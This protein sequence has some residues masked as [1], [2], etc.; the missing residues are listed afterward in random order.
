[1]RFIHV[2]IRF[3]LEISTSRLKRLRSLSDRCNEIS[4][5]FDV[6]TFLHPCSYT[7]YSKEKVY[8]TILLY[9]KRVNWRSE[10]S[11]QPESIEYDRWTSFT[12]RERR[13]TRRNFRKKITEKTT[14][15]RMVPRKTNLKK[16]GRLTVR[17]LP[18]KRPAVFRCRA[19]RGKTRG[20]IPESTVASR[21]CS[22]TPTQSRFAYLL[23]QKIVL[24]Y[25]F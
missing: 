2:F 4:D 8:K 5:L 15:L 12:F 3:I 23:T 17:R 14:E 6:L 7:H 18:G 9:N 20:V 1:M 21:Y 22:L 11:M 19:G 16:K 13:H 25:Y 24:V 10:S